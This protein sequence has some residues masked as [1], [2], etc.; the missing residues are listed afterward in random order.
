MH[1][2]DTQPELKNVARYKQLQAQ[3]ARTI[4]EEHNLQAKPQVAICVVASSSGSTAS[5]YT[6]QYNLQV[7]KKKQLA[8][9]LSNCWPMLF[10]RWTVLSP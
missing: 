1:L 5:N 6:K 3:V 9:H 2:C 4:V 10:I 8:T 7:K